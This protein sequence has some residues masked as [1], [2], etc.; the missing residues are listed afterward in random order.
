M[1]SVRK[2]CKTFDGCFIGNEGQQRTY[3]IKSTFLFQFRADN[4]EITIG[5]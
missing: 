3:C 2:M 5:I 4:W 1:T